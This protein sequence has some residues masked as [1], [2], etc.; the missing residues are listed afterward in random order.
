V[1]LVVPAPAPLDVA[2]LSS[3]TLAA[4]YGVK[5]FGD[6]PGRRG[7]AS[8]NFK[9][10]VL[11]RPVRLSDLSPKFS[12]DGFAQDSTNPERDFARFASSSPLA[13]YMRRSPATGHETSGG[14][15]VME[16]A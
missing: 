4:R 2:L 8:E 6:R 1:I 16:R 9:T 15:L 5:Q 10:A 14:D 13:L 11:N 3:S 12:P 7:T